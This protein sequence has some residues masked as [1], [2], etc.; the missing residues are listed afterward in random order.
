MLLLLVCVAT[1]GLGISLPAIFGGLISK[2]DSEADDEYREEDASLD[3]QE[4]KPT[5]HKP[6][7]LHIPH[8]ADTPLN[9]N[10]PHHPFHPD[11]RP[12]FPQLPSLP[13]F[14]RETIRAT[15]TVFVEVRIHQ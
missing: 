11:N 2:G 1:H 8:P 7:L 3:Q 5:T 6:P 4:K 12:H 9:P 15:K 14:T 10:N 13:H